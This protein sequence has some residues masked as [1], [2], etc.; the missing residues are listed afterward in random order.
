[1]PA[2]VSRSSRS[3]GAAQ[4]GG[5]RA[6]RGGPA[7]REEG[8][9]AQDHRGRHQGAAQGLGFVYEN[10]KVRAL[11]APAGCLR[12]SAAERATCWRPVPPGRRVGGARVRRSAA[13]SRSSSMT[14]PPA[15]GSATAGR[16]TRCAPGRTG[17]SPLSDAAAQPA[18]RRGC[19]AAGAGAQTWSREPSRRTAAGA[20]PGPCAALLRSVYEARGLEGPL[21]LPGKPPHAS[22]LA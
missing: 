8:A 9:Q 13:P 11:A 1:M 10:I 14:S 5:A 7:G 19:T 12:S 17:G 22:A 18:A 20:V 3:R 2:P 6:R 4:R 15:S 16:G 21:L